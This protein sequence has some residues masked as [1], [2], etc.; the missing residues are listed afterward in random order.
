[1]LKSCFWLRAFLTIWVNRR[2]YWDGLVCVRVNLCAFLYVCVSV[3]ICVCVI[4]SVFAYLCVWGVHVCVCVHVRGCMNLSGWMNLWG[5]VCTC[6]PEFVYVCVCMCVCLC[7]RACQF[8][9]RTGRNDEG[10]G[11]YVVVLTDWSKG[12]ADGWW[13]R[14][15]HNRARARACVCVCVCVCV[16][17]ASDILHCSLESALKMIHIKAYRWQLSWQFGFGK[18]ERQRGGDIEGVKETAGERNLKSNLSDRSRF[19]L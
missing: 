7:V 8:V 16:C 10:R 17:L 15:V 4:V 11:P 5:C 12:W 9:H 1:M 18:R 14:L 13:C 6:V 3:H 19:T 2:R